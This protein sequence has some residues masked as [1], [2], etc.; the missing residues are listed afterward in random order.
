MPYPDGLFWT[1]PLRSGGDDEEEDGN[2]VSVNLK[3]GTARM[4]AHDLH[5]T[6]FFNIPNALFRFQTPVSLPAT[7]AFDIRWSGPTTGRARVTTPGSSGEL[8]PSQATM[9]W[10]AT[11]QSGFKF[12][13]NASPT[14]SFFAQLG[15]VN[16]GV[17]AARERDD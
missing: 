11:N 6:D 1:V 5:V 17:F 12:R 8:F 13:S 2:A 9:T 15:H 16:N 4:A 3:A 14:T 7:I 10:S